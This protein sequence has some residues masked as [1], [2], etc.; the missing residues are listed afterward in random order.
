MHKKKNDRSIVFKHHIEELVENFKDIPGF[1]VGNGWSKTYFDIDK[2]K[3]IGIIIACNEAFKEHHV[4]LLMFQ[5]VDKRDLFEKIMK[6]Y[7][8]KVMH[9]SIKKTWQLEQ[10][11]EQKEKIFYYDLRRSFK[12]YNGL[13]KQLSGHMAFQLAYK[14]GC[15]PIILIGVDCCAEGPNKRLNTHNLQTRTLAKEQGKWT[16]TTLKASIKP[17]VKVYREIK[18]ERKVFKLGNYGLLPFPIISWE[19]V[20]D[21]D[22]EESHHA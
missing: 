1:V 7:P 9:K 8:L 15:N 11:A 21:R 17:L 14:L 6:S 3:D 20:L 5:D 19:Q 2:L 13:M 12:H 18:D 10:V 16:T 4:D 22:F